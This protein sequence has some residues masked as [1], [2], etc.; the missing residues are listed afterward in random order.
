MHPPATKGGKVEL[1]HG[2][3]SIRV[4]YFQGPKW[5]VELVLRVAGPGEKLRVFTLDEF[6][7]HAE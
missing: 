3:H 6:R 2:A 1:A 5:Y 4:P 7:P